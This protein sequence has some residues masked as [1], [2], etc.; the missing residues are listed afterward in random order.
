MAGVHHV[1]QRVRASA[2]TTAPS[3]RARQRSARAPTPTQPAVLAALRRARPC[4]WRR[5]APASAR[6]P[7][8]S[9]A[10]PF[11]R[12]APAGTG[13]ASCRGCCSRPCRRCPGTRAPRASSIGGTGAKPLPS[14]MFDAG[15][16]AANTPRRAMHLEVGSSL[17]A[18]RQCAAV[19][20]HV[21]HAPGSRSSCT[22]VRPPWRSLH[23]SCCSSA[24]PTRAPARAGPAPSRTA[25]RSVPRPAGSTC[26][27]RGRRSPPRS[28]RRP[29]PGTSARQSL[30]AAAAAGV[31]LS[32]PLG[33]RTHSSRVAKRFALTARCP[34]PP[35]R[36]PPCA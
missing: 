33:R 36:P 9:P 10:A 20:G 32:N 2:P 26:T 1:H 28:A 23:S 16:A 3:R 35:A 19:V 14:F 22:G 5:R 17:T 8:G 27:R 31:A 11:A 4:A 25:A 13:P 30:E 15:F 24:S 6:P 34:P 29:R 12:A 7:V 18:T 21:Q